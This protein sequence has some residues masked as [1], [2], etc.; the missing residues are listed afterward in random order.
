M[1]ITIGPKQK[2][3]VPR[4]RIPLPPAPALDL[5]VPG[6][7]RSEEVAALL[8]IGKSTL[9]AH[10]AAGQVPKPY[11]EGGLAFWSTTA[12]REHLENPQ[13]KP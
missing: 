13:G 9:R 1:T 3:K 10:V 11:Y 7:L 12:I 5:S 8:R 4:R 6:R 2:P